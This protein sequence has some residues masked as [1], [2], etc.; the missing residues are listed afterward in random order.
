MSRTEA[1]LEAQLE[2]LRCYYNFARPNQS[3]RQGRERRTPAMAAG[4][5][6]RPLT[7]RE[8]FSTIIPASE[9]RRAAWPPPHRLCSEAK[10]QI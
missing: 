2:L 1:S 7:L 4:L 3:L 9:L 8:I 6:T 10:F 5:A